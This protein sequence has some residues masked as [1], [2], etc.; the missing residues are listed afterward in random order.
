MDIAAGQSLK[1]FELY[2]L[3]LDY[4]L[5]SK[6]LRSYDITANYD[7]DMGSDHRNV[8]TSLEIIRSRHSWT[9]RRASFKG[10][11]SMMDA[12]REP[13]LYHKSS[14]RLMISSRLENLH[15]LEK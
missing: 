6:S 10:W 8:S 1:S 9:R 14:Y 12:S 7:L 13:H 2:L 5:H 11:K 3:R 15:E 4:I